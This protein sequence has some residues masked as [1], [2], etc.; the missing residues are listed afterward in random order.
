MCVKVLLMLGGFGML[1]CMACL[2]HDKLI[3]GVH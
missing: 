2:F 3:K 1:S